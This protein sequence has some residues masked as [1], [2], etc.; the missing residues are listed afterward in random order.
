[1]CGFWKE[2]LTEP[3]E[4][5]DEPSHGSFR[6][7]L[8]DREIRL[9]LTCYFLYAFITNGVLELIPLWFWAHTD[10]GGL[11]WSVKYIGLIMIG[12]VLFNA[13]L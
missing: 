13:T 11:E 2:T 7:L 3:T 5:D 6:E 4:E 10:H 8:K 9:L 1:M 12:S